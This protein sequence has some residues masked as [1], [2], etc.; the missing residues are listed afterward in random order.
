[1]CKKKV[2]GWDEERVAINKRCHNLE[3]IILD[4]MWSHLSQLGRG[5]LQSLASS[6]STKPLIVAC[7]LKT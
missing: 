2:D 4:H 7:D 6:T 3:K 5:L 1:M